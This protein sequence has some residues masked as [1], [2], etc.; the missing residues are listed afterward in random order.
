MAKKIPPTISLP[1]K[2]T[3]GKPRF[4]KNVIQVASGTVSVYATPRI[5]KALKE[6]IEDMTFY[7]GVRLSQIL[8]AIYNQGK[9]DGANDAFSE[10]DKKVKEVKKVIPHRNPGQPKKPK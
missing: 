4:V 10:I 7:Q 2:K 3:I 1:T 9:K 6:I 5:S 8:E